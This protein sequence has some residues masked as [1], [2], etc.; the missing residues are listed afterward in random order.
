MLTLRT[1][2]GASWSVSSRVTGRLIDFLTLLV[3]ARTLAPGD[4]GLT[5]LAMS[6]VAVVDVIL[7]VPLIQALTR[8]HSVEKAHLDTAFTLGLLRSVVLFALMTGAAFSASAIYADPNLLMLVIALSIGPIARGLVSPNMVRFVR[9]LHFRQIFITEIVGKVGAA[10]LAL[11]VLY[12]GG[13]YWAIATN[14]IAASSIAAIIS[15]VLAPYRPGLSLQR[16]PE[17]RELLGWFSFAQMVSALNWQLDRIILGHFIPRHTLG[18]YA[19]AGDIAALPTQSLIGPAMQ[20]LMA[21]FSRIHQDRDR[22]RS[23]Y[24]KASRFAM[25][26]AVPA[27]VGMSL[28]SELIVSVVLGPKWME[29]AIYL[30]LISLTIVLNAYFQ[31]LYSLSI[32]VNGAS[33]VFQLNSIDFILRILILVPIIYYLSIMGAIAARGILSIVAFGLCM[34]YARRLLGISIQSQLKN[35]WK[36]AAACVLMALFVAGLSLYL[37]QS[38][39]PPIIELAATAGSG[40]AVYVAVLYALGVR[41]RTADVRFL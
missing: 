27:C 4:F 35:L 30:Q 37:A 39:L 11:L 22:L 7:E 16:W 17:F 5:A 33:T 23:A 2:L 19:M 36:L 9:E 3:L 28:T 14:N 29:S 20:P 10:A 38:G 13:G 32:I 18:Q 15:Y 6:I 34:L 25:L 1:L 26:I 8:L 40:A 12:Q 21:A 31:P 24:L 41:L